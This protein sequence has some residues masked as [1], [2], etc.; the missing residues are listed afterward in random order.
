MGHEHWTEPKEG[1]RAGFGRFKKLPTP[2]DLF[3][4]SEGIPVFRDIGMRDIR[5][6]PLAPWKRKS[7]G[8]RWCS[9]SQPC[10]LPTPP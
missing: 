1:E 10:S 8:S 6:L 3:M 9:R 2:Y 4:E 7:P 5:E